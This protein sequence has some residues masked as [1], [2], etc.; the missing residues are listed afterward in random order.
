MFPDVRHKT[1]RLMK[2]MLCTLFAALGLLGLA[3]AQEAAPQEIPSIRALCIAAPVPEGVDAFIDFIQKELAPRKLNTLVLRVD[4][5]YRYTSHPALQGENALSREDARKLA[6]ACKAHGINLIP[7]LNLLGHQSWQ[8][9]P[10]KL[11]EVYPEFDETPHIQLPEQY[12]W[13][14]EDGLYCKSYCP[15]HPGL[16]QVVFALIDELMDAFDATSFHAGMDEVFYIGDERCPRCQGRDKAELFAGEVRAI[17]RHLL[18][19]GHRLWIWGDRLLDGK[20]TGIGMWEAS[21]N[22]T[23]RAID[24]IPKEVVIC[25]WHYNRAELTPA[26]FALKG[27]Q[28][29]ACPWNKPEVALEQLALYQHAQKNAN[30]AQAYRHRGLMQTIW[31]PAEAFLDAFYGR[32]PFAGRYQGQVECFL[33][34]FGAEW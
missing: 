13:P 12:Q 18:R 19:R 23:H 17:Y 33:A 28:T 31:S 21:M 15:L 34:L 9:E 11:L 14:N 1:T 24:L 3:A 25:D 30:A 5:N 6:A 10:G 29:V 16:H 32:K 7:Q 4:Y 26:Y 22:D 27:F 8:S 20:T 2:R